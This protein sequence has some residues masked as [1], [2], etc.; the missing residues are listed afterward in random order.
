[1]IGVGGSEV[2]GR[3]RTLLNRW[4]RRTSR[5]RRAASWSGFL[6]CSG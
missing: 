2:S 5:A 6:G 1:M 4:V 3:H